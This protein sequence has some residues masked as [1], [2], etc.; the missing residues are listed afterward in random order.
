MLCTLRAWEDERFCRDRLGRDKPLGAIDREK[1][2]VN[3]GSLAAGHPFAATG[4][5]IVA[6]LA[7]ELHERGSGRGVISICA[8]GGQG[9]VAI[10]ES[11][12]GKDEMSD[13]YAQVVNS[14]PRQADRPAASACPSRTSW[15]ATRPAPPVVA[16][17]R[18]QRR[19]PGRPP[20][21]AARAAARRDRR[22]TRPEVR[23][24][25][26]GARLRR[27]RDRRLDRAGRA[28]ALLPPQRDAG[29]SAPAA[30]SCS[31][32][33]RPAC[34]PARRPRSGRWRASPAR[35]GKEIGRGIA[36]QLVYV[37]EGAEDELDSTLRF[38]LSPRSAYVSGQVIRIG[39]G[40]RRRPSSNGSSRSTASWRW[41]P[42]PRAASARRSPPILHR[43]GAE[44]V[45]LD[46]PALA[47]RPDARSPTR[48]DGRDDR[49]R[50][51]RPD[52]AP[53][54]IAERSPTA[55]TSSS[56]TPASP[57]TARSPRCRRTA[58]AR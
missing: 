30:S 11:P 28:A 57:A 25:G 1:L 27:H 26:R 19:R 42:A 21:Q 51:H 39:Q 33:R 38:L 17:R 14:P 55:S 24:P 16:G 32:R 46:V 4:G 36:V 58:G 41:S 50:H 45:L 18:A 2:N 15:S 47:G 44:L 52:D 43:D 54:T 35:S 37:A 7:K 53:A 23:G 9:V 56:T 8:A 40:V 31:A 10:L 13:L 34:R 49:A 22:R 6:C 48:L 3:G 5:R 12:G 20:R 29:A